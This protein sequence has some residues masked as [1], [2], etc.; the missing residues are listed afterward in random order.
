[1]PPIRCALR[2]LALL[3]LA[4]A[5]TSPALMAQAPGG[6]PI[7]IEADLRDAPRNLVHARLVIP[8]AP[9]PLTLY[10]PKW[11]P[12][13]HSPSGPVR[14]LA[15]LH[16]RAGGQ[17]IPWHRDPLDMFALE[18]DVPAGAAAIE[19]QLDNLSP[20]AGGNF[21]AGPSTSVALAM[22]SWNTIVLYPGGRPAE[23]ITFEPSVVLPAGWGHASGLQIAAEEPG[24]VRYAPVSLVR[25]I[26]SPVLAGANFRRVELPGAG[27]AHA[28]DVAA[29]SPG[30]LVTP[31]GFAEAYAR[32]VAEAKA[33]FGAQHYAHYDWLLSLSDHVEHFGLEH[34]ESSDDRMD[35]RTLLEEARRNNLASLLAHE[36]VHSWNGKFRRPAGLVRDDYQ[37]PY[38][39]GLLWVYEGLTQYLTQLL[40][41]RAGLWSLDYGRERL[42]LIAANL[43]YQAGRRWRPLADTA[44]AAQILYGVRSYWRSW[45]RGTDFYDESVL[46]W[47]EVDAG[48]RRASKGSRSLDD[49]CHAF[50]GGAENGPELKPYTFDEVVA[51]LGS[52]APGDWRGLLDQRL[53]AT[54]EHAPLSGLEAAGWKLVFDDKPNAAL[55]DREKI[56][57]SVD[58]SYS[59]GFN[60]DKTG[61]I[62]DVRVGS[63]ADQAGVAPGAKLLAIDGLAYSD[64]RLAEAVAAS[65]QRQA[66]I[67]LLLQSGEAFRSFRLDYHGG[68]R[69]PH[70]VRN[71]QPDLLTV[72]QAPRVRPARPAKGH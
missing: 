16:F 17:E 47:M 31:P 13:E 2:S 32:L 45:R 21:S 40:P 27:R 62:T 58:V 44:T 5:G 37:Q 11:I 10:Y 68:A 15:G 59:L 18:L 36:Y 23:Q 67:E 12:G 39:T 63:P 72:M 19:V 26:D 48:L 43:E 53:Q 29:D 38:D 33:L 71:D 1:M 65:P 46:I 57:D 60:V 8:A 41:V 30:A 28:I 24:K 9:G 22:L 70:L 50:H 7:H 14:D 25:L 35:E 20:V 52:V 34:H 6:P 4:L 55:T 64:D 54:G 69:Y 42:A 66:P 49:F 56:D 51:T 3:A 61:M